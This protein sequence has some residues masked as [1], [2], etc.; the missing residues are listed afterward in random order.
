[1]KIL[2][3]PI[4][5]DNYIWI[6]TTPSNDCIIV[7]PGDGKPVIQFLERNNLSPK[8]ILLTHHHWDHTGGVT[9]LSAAYPGLSIFGPQETSATRSNQLAL[10]GTKITAAG[11]PIQLIATPGHTLDH[12]SYYLV[13][14][15]KRPILFC[16]D[17]LFSAGCGRLFEGTAKQ[18]YNSM[19]KLANLPDNTQIY[20]AHEYT[21]ENLIF[22]RMVDPGNKFLARYQK[23]I[24]QARNRGY[25]SLPTTLW[26]EKKINPFL[27]CH[28]QNIQNTIGFSG[29][30]AWEVF[31]ELRRRKDDF[32]S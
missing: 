30:A 24:G 32:R 7:D 28:E 20:C 5:K 14:G 26:V 21:V 2:N 17:T 31:T 25:P 9:E 10:D 11:I 13:N 23:K 12:L 29:A 1:M 8:A 27:R 4:F 18:M 22:A 3:I 15:H 6:I 19:Q 16:G